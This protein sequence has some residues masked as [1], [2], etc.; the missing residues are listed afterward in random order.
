VVTKYGNYF[1]MYEKIVDENPYATPMMIYPALHNGRNLGYYNLQPL[2]VSIGESNFSDHVQIVGAS[3]LM[4]GLGYIL[5][6]PY[7]VI[8]CLQILNGTYL[9]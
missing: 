8:I 2:D 5:Y 1:Q 7:T 4:Q 6:C 3:A 9:Y